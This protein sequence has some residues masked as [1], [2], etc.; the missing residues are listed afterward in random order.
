MLTNKVRQMPV[1]TIH[2]PAGDKESLK[3][4]AQKRGMQ[5]TTYCRMVLLQSLEAKSE[6][7]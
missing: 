3:A 1:I 5:L 6:R 2:I 7:S 4:E